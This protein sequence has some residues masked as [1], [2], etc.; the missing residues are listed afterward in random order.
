[1]GQR[2]SKEGTDNLSTQ[3]TEDI[4]IIRRV[5][6]NG[7]SVAVSEYIDES[8][9]RWKKAQVKLAIT[10]RTKTGKSTFINKIRNLNPGDDDF[11][12]TGY[13]NTTITPTLYMHPRNDHIAFCDLPGYSTTIFK[14]ENYISEMKISDYHFFFI[15]FDNV[16]SEDEVWLVREL[17]KLG[18]PFS[19]VRSKI[20]IAIENAIHDGKEQEMIIP[21]IKK[22]M[23]NALDA[24]PELNDAKRI[25]LIS[26]RAPHFGEMSDL[27]RY[28]EEN[29]DG[30]KA[31]ALL[32]SLDSI[33]KE[34]V[35]RKYKMLKKRLVAATA[36]ATGIAAIPV[37]GVDVAIITTLLVHEVHHY[38]SVFGVNR[39]RVYSLKDFDHAILKCR[40]LLEPNFNMVLFVSAKLGTYAALMY[41]AS[42]LDLLLPLIGYT[43]SS[44]IAARVTYRF[45]DDMLHDINHDAV[46]IYEHVVKTNADHRM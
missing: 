17:R 20:D 39:Q 38:M 41:A 5:A 28:V 43:I 45:L 3:D 40:S 30:F 4:N 27:M 44:A 6:E 29:I 18:K 8:I 36:H 9:N 10:G 16:L 7:G 32:F 11:A 2:Q 21:E 15:F 12:K 22:E 19:L 23:K 25:F 14:K 37:P 46:L 24:N 33:T 31:E 26:S 34:I 1:M 13:G 35:E 42:F